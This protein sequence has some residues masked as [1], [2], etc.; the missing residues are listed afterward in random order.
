[1]GLTAIG[2][3][4][5]SLRRIHYE[6]VNT[7][8]T[9]HLANAI[10]TY[11]DSMYQGGACGCGLAVC[12]AMAKQSPCSGPILDA[13]LAKTVTVCPSSGLALCQFVVPD[14]TSSHLAPAP[15]F[16]QCSPTY[17]LLCMHYKKC[18]VTE[19]PRGAIFYC[20]HCN[21]YS[22]VVGVLSPEKI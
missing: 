9:I 15:S 1:M 7:N 5:P 20:F 6:K 8:P 17:L 3:L 2:L 18:G 10:N 14:S 12:D 11:I 19:H 13:N 4:R 22:L 16:L 21:P